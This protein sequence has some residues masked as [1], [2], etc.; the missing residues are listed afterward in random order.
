MSFY[1]DHSTLAAM[2]SRCHAIHLQ[3]LRAT[4]SRVSVISMKLHD[5][6]VHE[7]RPSVPSKRVITQRNFLHFAHLRSYHASSSSDK[8]FRNTL[9]VRLRLFT[10]FAD[11]HCHFYIRSQPPTSPRIR[12]SPVTNC[13]FIDCD[14]SAL[15][16]STIDNQSM[17][18]S[19][20][21]TMHIHTNVRSKRFDI[22]ISPVLILQFNKNN[23]GKH[24]VALL[25]PLPNI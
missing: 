19:P 18:P 25:A 1:I 6:R 17:Q 13:Q 14:T 4:L 2:H 21:T 9:Q 3:H 23:R 16:N 24:L 7:I 8:F 10:T 22:I 11:A 20:A 15:T 5:F 12:V